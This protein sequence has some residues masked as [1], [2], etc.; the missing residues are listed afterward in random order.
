MDR[1]KSSISKANSY[2]E[3]GEFWSTHDLTEFWEQT[4]PVE[5]EPDIQ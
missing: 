1:S 3:T 4:Q 5:F 2:R